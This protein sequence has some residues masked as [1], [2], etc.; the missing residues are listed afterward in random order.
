MLNCVLSAGV[1]LSAFACRGKTL[2]SSRRWPGIV[3]PFM[4]PKCAA[5][6]GSVQPVWS[7]VG[8]RKRRGP[9]EEAWAAR[10]VPPHALLP[11]D[12]DDSSLEAPRP[13]PTISSHEASS[14]LDDCSSRIGRKCASRDCSFLVHTH[15]SFGDFCCKMCEKNSGGRHGKKCERRAYRPSQT[16]KLPRRMLKSE[17]VAFR[18]GAVAVGDWRDAS[19]PDCLAV[20]RGDRFLKAEPWDDDDAWLYAWRWRRDDGGGGDRRQEGYVPY[21]ALSPASFAPALP[22]LIAV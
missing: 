2:A 16:S 20:R 19:E 14:E 5:A 7:C 1:R 3:Q 13:E 15:P 21:M 8:S 22:H 18:S 17:E 6:E 9:P 11:L 10:F 12:G 4:Q